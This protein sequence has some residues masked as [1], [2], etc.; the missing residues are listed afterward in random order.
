MHHFESVVRALRRSGGVT[1]A[2]AVPA[3]AALGNSSSVVASKGIRKMQRFESVVLQ[4]THEQ[5]A[6]LASA[7]AATDRTLSDLE[8]LISSLKSTP[9]LAP[10]PPTHPILPAAAEGLCRA[11]SEPLATT[12]SPRKVQCKSR[13]MEVR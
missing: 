4:R 2:D 12:G 9:T 3:A 8:A 10:P 11:T 6:D 5:A 13:Y 1:A 7:A